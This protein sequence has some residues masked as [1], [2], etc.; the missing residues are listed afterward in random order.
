M[1][2]VLS[3][4]ANRSALDPIECYL[5]SLFILPV[6]TLYAL[7]IFPAVATCS[8]QHSCSHCWLFFGCW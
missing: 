8:A 6:H 2:N 7:L 5:L 3:G 1:I 4:H